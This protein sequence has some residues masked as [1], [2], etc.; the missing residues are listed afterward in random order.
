M[1]AFIGAALVMI[2]STAIGFGTA[3]EKRRR[4]LCAE[5]F[6]GLVEHIELSLP[7]LASLEDII[8]G[9]DNGTLRQEGVMDTLLSANSTLPCNKRLAL[10]IE[11]QRE[12]K[13]LYGALL[14]LTRELGNTDYTRQSQ[15]IAQVKASLYTLSTARRA[16]LHKEE[17]CY[18]WLGV[19]AG[20]AAVILLI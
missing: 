4:T 9:Y 18:K 20:M 3:R 7:S 11:L 1:T 17:R 10:A 2:A 16:E 15:S 14:P 12:D 19:L 6:Y 13:A 8:R 5:G